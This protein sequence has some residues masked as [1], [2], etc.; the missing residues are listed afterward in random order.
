M[1]V[2]LSS[3]AQATVQR[4]I[5]KAAATTVIQPTVTGMIPGNNATNVSRDTAVSTLLSL[6]FGG[7]AAGTVSATSVGLYRTSD[8]L[9]IPANVNTTGGGDSIILTPT[10]LLPANTRFT[11]VVTAHVKDIQGHALAPFV[12]HFTTGST[13]VPTTAAYTFDHVA[14][15]TTAGRTYTAVTMGPDGK[16]YAATL[17]GLILRFPVNA[18]G[19]LGSPTSIKLVQQNNGGNRYLL[20]LAFQPGST[21]TNMTLWVSHGVYAATGGADWTCK[22]SKLTDA[23]HD[24]TLDTYKDVVVGL[25]RSF[26][27]HMTDQLVFGPDGNIYF[28]QGS[29]SAMGAPDLTWGNRAEHPLSGAI[30]KLDLG[31][32]A[33]TSLPL[34]VKTSDGG[35]KYNPDA[36]NAPLT[37]YASGVRN[38]YDL[39]WDSNGKLYAPSN[40]SAAGGNTPQAP[41]KA[42]TKLT[43]VN[44]TEDDWFFTIQQGKYYGHPNPT[45][46]YYVLNGGNPTSGADPQQINQYKV[47]TTPDAGWMPATLDLGPNHSAN[48][49][50]E[51]KGGAFGGALDGT[52]F[53]CQYSG[54]DNLLA[55]KPNAS[56]V[57]NVTNIGGLTGFNGP[58]D[59][60]QGP[61]GVI[62]V[63]EHDGGTI[64]LLRPRTGS[65][66]TP[67]PTPTPTG[68]SNV[69]YFSAIVG[70]SNTQTL[71]VK[72]TTASAV[73]LSAA[74]FAISGA[75]ASLFKLASS[76]AFPKTVPAGGQVSITLNFT[77]P[78]GTSAGVKTATVSITSNGKVLQST[79]L[80]GLA[81]AGASGTG[82]PSLQRLLDFWQIPV[83]VGD[84]DPNTADLPY[85][86]LSTTQSVSLPQLYKASPSAPV[87]IQPIGVFAPAGSPT[88]KAGYYSIP[89]GTLHQVLTT[90]AGESETAIVH[91][92]GSTAFDPGS[93]PFNLYATFPGVAGGRT[94][95]AEDTRNTWETDKSRRHKVR[96]FPLR[97]PDNTVVPNAYVVA[98]E[99]ISGAYDYQDFVEIV[100]NVATTPPL[101]TP[102]PAPTPTPTPAP[103][104]TPT[105]A[106]ATSKGT[107]TN[108]TIVNADTRATILQIA[109]GATID[110]AKLPT[111]H[112]SIQAAAT[113]TVGSVRFD[114]DGKVGYHTENFAPYTLT[115]DQGSGYVPW[116]ATLGKHTLSVTSFSS[117]GGKGTAGSSLKVQFTLVDSSLIASKIA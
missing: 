44:Q 65:T 18:D 53:I 24:G 52:I 70:G 86:L 50:I 98:Y 117:A 79:S 68:A 28:G 80:R 29:M 25:P 1:S 104:P 12:G 112:I 111:R 109:S 87:T 36:A 71:L 34:N 43:N 23:N 39:L 32:L 78:G 77:L 21:A 51:Y 116:S 58:L 6:P 103:T 3:A 105:A 110:L 42:G 74:S 22:I 45:R 100:R 82:E 13:P 90:G 38:A 60:T 107:L 30:L 95:Y 63:A 41:G 92:V 114:L 16:L 49:I 84:P 35:G 19:T 10:S 5:V 93:A 76:N 72:N 69:V 64:T 89:S 97:N 91:P 75:N 11:F 37:V 106:P 46:G 14:L 47:G 9:K 113:S 99:E 96:F 81:A 66:P 94:V 20:G 27:D 101:A 15:P 56:G 85:N 62:Y 48:G 83:V 88:V 61:N 8:G 115:N 17:E 40:G 73:S 7:L 102:T 26:R 108:L 33:K 59:L 4:S 54:G 67:T 31:K 55:L 2:A 57:T